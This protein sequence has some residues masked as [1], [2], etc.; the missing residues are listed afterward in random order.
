MFSSSIRLLTALSVMAFSTSAFAAEASASGSTDRF[1]SGGYGAPDLRLSN[2]AGSAGLFMGSQGGW[3]INHHFVFGGAGYGLVNDV[4][5]T[6]GV[7]RDVSFA[8]GGFRPGVMFGVAGDA[9]HITGGL[10]LGAA[11]V[12]LGDG[13]KT[14]FVAEPDVGLDFT[15]TSWLRAGVSASYRFGAPVGEGITRLAFNDLSGPA[16]GLNVKFGSF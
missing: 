15:I 4:K 1:E 9:L 10:L 7:P 8:Y 16:A 13:S 11:G 12:S 5:L 2:V 14:T 6:R 3:I